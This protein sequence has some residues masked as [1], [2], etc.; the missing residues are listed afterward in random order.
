MKQIFRVIVCAALFAGLPAFADFEKATEAFEKGDYETTLR[1]LRPL[2]EQGYAPAQYN[3]GLMYG[4]GWGVPQDYQRAL[5]WYKL[6]A[7]QGHVGAQFN[8]GNMYN[9]GHGVSQDGRQAVKWLTLAAENRHAQAQYNLAVLYY[10]GDGVPQDYVRVHLWF[11]LAASNGL[12]KGAESRDDIAKSM[13]TEQI[14]E[15][16]KRASECFAKDYKGC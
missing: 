1:E 11:N 7:E 10:K 15:A 5:K 8:V 12:E 4:N 6:S 16:Q 14:A 3:L 9:D 13:T 2:A